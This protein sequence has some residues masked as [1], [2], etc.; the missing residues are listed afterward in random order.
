M[1]QLNKNSIQEWLPFDEILDSGIIKL[2]NQHYI[3]I[4]SVSPINYN[5]KSELEKQSIITSYELFLKTCN[6]DIQFIIQ[7][8][9]EDFREYFSYLE[10]ESKKEN[11]TI[12]LLTEEYIRYLKQL[13]SKTQSSSKKFF[14]IIETSELLAKQ[15]NSEKEALEEL[16]E[17]YH[18]IK[19][20]LARC[21]NEV[22]DYTSKLQVYH[23]LQSFFN[24]KEFYQ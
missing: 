10:K 2:K 5:L 13:S 14:M 4:L 9:K 22:S 8:N 20:C 24:K 16:N 1:K 12:Q 19:E 21:G 23:I 18:K 6:F 17:K 3:K 15:E 7:S 11:K